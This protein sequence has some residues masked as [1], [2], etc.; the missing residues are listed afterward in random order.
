M[1]ERRSGGPRL[2]GTVA[3]LAALVLGAALSPAARAAEPLRVPWDVTAFVG[4]GASPDTAPGTNDFSCKPAPGTRPV[5]LVHGLAGTLGTNWATM[6]PLL[7]NNGFCVFGLT[8]GKT[9]GFPL[10]AGFTR[11]ED[12]S[13]E[14]AALVDRVLRS[15]GA[16]KVDL[17]G[18]SEGTVMPRWYLSFRGGAKKVDKY[19]QLTPLWKGTNLVGLGDLADAAAGLG[20]PGRQVAELL[21]GPLCGSCAQFLRGSDYLKKVNAAGPAI[22]GITYTGIATKYDELVTPYTSGLLDAPN[23]TNVVLQ[24]V[25]PN[26]LSEH[27][28]VAYS[29]NAAQLVLNALAPDR[30]RKVRCVAMTPLGY[31]GPDPGVR[32]DPPP[33]TPAAAKDDRGGADAPVVR[34]TGSAARCQAPRRLTIRVRPTN[35]PIRTATVRVGTERVSTRRA[36]GTRAAQGRKVAT[37]DLRRRAGRTV[38]VRSTATLRARDRRGR[39]VRVGDV[40]QYRV[41][42]TS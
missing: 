2:R 18:H 31:F 20:L 23:V 6:A 16:D 21:L 28:A 5:V 19:V 36:P 39:I 3:V 25:C 1:G 8:Y 32:L 24:D 33:A 12:S 40:R 11:M 29:P 13:A 27:L 35:R 7:K 10:L 15:T 17:V 14:L 38:V 4:G 37:V 42:A 9:L 30:A 22:P 41:C 34:P 26:D